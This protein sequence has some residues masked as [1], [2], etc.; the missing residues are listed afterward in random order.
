[1]NDSTIF[2][3]F[4][5]WAQ[6]TP[7]IAKIVYGNRAALLNGSA[8]GR[9]LV[10]RPTALMVVGAIVAGLVGLLGFVAT[11]LMPTMLTGA[12]TA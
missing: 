8:I 9:L 12:S 10:G 6:I 11:A 3:P 1:M 5:A 2:I 4:H 7:R